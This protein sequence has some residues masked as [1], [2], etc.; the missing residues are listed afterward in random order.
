ML[1][2]HAPQPCLNCALVI[3]LPCYNCGI[4]VLLNRAETVPEPSINYLNLML[5]TMP[6]SCLNHAPY[7]H[8][9]PVPQPCLNYHAITKIMP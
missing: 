1:L 3:P 7:Y 9:P 6:L 2:N 5:L 4:T 8:A